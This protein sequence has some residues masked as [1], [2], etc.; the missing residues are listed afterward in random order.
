MRCQQPSQIGRRKSHYPLTYTYL[1]QCYPSIC[2][3]QRKISSLFVSERTGKVHG[4]F[5][6]DID[7]EE[8]LK[9]VDS[10]KK[11]LKLRGID[12]DV[13]K[14]VQDYYRMCELERQRVHLEVEKKRIGALIASLLKIKNE[15]LVSKEIEAQIEETKQEGL[16][17]KEAIKKLM[18]EWWDQEETLQLAIL[19]LPN[20]LLST[21]PDKDPLLIQEFFQEKKIPTS[22]SHVELVKETGLVKFSNIGPRSYFLRGKLAELEQSLI[23]HVSSQLQK[24]GFLQMVGP[25]MFKTTLV[26]SAGVS[27][28]E[29]LDIYQLTEKEKDKDALIQDKLWLRGSSHMTFLALLTRNVMQENQLPM[30]MFNIGRNYIPETIA[31]SQLPGLF[32]ALQTVKIAGCC[33][34]RSVKDNTKELYECQTLLSDIYRQFKLPYRLIN[35]PVSSL[36]PAEQNRVEI[37]VWAPSLQQFLKVASLSNVSDYGSRRLMIRCASRRNSPDTHPVY[38]VDIDICDL[39]RLIALLIEY[40]KYNEEIS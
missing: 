25:D 11:N 27:Y 12:F 6:H 38:M 22:Q 39:T 32:G 19:A 24:H 28:S 35:M 13:D 18:P 4:Y 33:V 5:Q 16:E 2:H 31:G 7:I 40:G 30:R 29:P 20:H 37:Q 9:D 17:V 23:G 10:L 3:Q 14:L 36:S 1:C 8:R 26:E 21:V 34:N 15:Q